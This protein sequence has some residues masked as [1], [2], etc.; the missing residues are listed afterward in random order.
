MSRLDALNAKAPV[1]LFYDGHCPFCRI[2]VDWLSRHRHHQRIRLVDIQDESFLS[3]EYGASFGTMMG[4]LHV[5]D[6]AGHWYIGMD[7]SRALYAVLGYQRLVRF[8]CLPGIN[9]IMDAGYRLFARYRIQL[10]RWWDKR[11]KT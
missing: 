7:A 2:E 5:L 4:K 10:G 9:R 8:S 3:G 11:K 6:N 1:T